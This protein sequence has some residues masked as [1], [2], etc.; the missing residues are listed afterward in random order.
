MGQNIDWVVLELALENRLA[1]A[2]G[3]A[4]QKLF[5]ESWKGS[6]ATISFE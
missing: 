4:F 6:M 1:N 5:S 3:N 2:N